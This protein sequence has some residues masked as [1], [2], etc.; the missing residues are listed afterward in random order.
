[1]PT[2]ERQEE[3]VR[4]G[5]RQDSRG[6]QAQQKTEVWLNLMESENCFCKTHARMA[7]LVAE[8]LEVSSTGLGNR[9]SASM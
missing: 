3:N 7:A 2:A 6:A 4:C 1:M 5:E 8:V 9:G